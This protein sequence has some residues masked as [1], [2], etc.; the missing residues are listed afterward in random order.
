MVS[1]E[2]V[3][4]KINKINKERDKL[5]GGGDDETQVPSTNN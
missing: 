5:I 4:A 2:I 3:Y 1:S